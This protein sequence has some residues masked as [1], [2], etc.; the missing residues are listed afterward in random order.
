MDAIIAWLEDI[1][2]WI[3][4]IP[5]SI[6]CYV[7]AFSNFL[8]DLLLYIPRQI[9][10]LFC[11]DWVAFLALIPVPSF[12]N[13][14]HTYIQTVFNVCGYWFNI[15]NLGYGLSIIISAMLIKFIIRRIPFVG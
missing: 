12:F 10:A 7:V 4:C 1:V 6:K 11:Q 15:L 5:Y 9:F 2:Q 3:Q 8:I 14:A 13:D